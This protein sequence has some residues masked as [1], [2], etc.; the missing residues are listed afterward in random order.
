MP[1]VWRLGWRIHFTCSNPGSAAAAVSH[2]ALR[3]TWRTCTSWSNQDAVAL[4]RLSWANLG[5]RCLR[6]LTRRCIP[7]AWGRCLVGCGTFDPA[8]RARFFEIREERKTEEFRR[9]CE[10]LAQETTDPDT[11]FLKQHEL[12]RYIDYYDPLPPGEPDNE[13][14][15]FDIQAHNETWHEYAAAAGGKALPGGILSYQEPCDN[16]PRN[17]RSSSRTNDPGQHSASHSSAR[18]PRMG[19]LR[20][21]SVDLKDMRAKT[22][23]CSSAN[24]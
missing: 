6:L 21:Q 5:V 15:P 10:L 1:G 13:L 7:T 22:F 17:I 20:A 9:Q 3:S 23:S 11:L 12:G 18:I 8:S 19:A 24:G 14:P 2:C 16:A 4:N